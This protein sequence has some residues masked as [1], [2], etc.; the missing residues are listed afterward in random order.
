MKI[1]KIGEKTWRIGVIHQICQ[2]LYPP[3]FF[4]VR[5]ISIYWYT[6]RYI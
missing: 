2:R 6:Y 5:Y 1:V 3:M 4:T